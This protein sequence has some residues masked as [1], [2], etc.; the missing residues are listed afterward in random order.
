[1]PE[2]GCP[3]CDASIARAPPAVQH[4]S[5]SLAPRR[6]APTGHQDSQIRPL[7]AL[8][9]H[10]SRSASNVLGYHENHADVLI[11]H[12]GRSYMSN[13]KLNPIAYRPPRSRALRIVS[14]SPTAW[15]CLGRRPAGPW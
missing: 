8:F 2:A 6:L 5:R 1:M 15:R 4:T 9:R 14:R 11:R 12:P 3:N 13:G 10:D 7:Q